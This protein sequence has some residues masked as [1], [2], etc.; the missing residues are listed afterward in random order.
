MKRR[1]IFAADFSYHP[2]LIVGY[3]LK[4]RLGLQA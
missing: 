4:Q 3:H 1:Q 2:K